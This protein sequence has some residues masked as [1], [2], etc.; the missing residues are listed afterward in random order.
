VDADTFGWEYDVSVIDEATTP[1]EYVLEIEAGNCVE[2][3]HGGGAAHRHEHR[4]ER[5]R[6]RPRLLQR[7]AAAG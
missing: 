2:Y 4:S 6:H 1:V 7:H 5:L 3:G